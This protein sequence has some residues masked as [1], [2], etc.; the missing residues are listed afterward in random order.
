[1]RCLACAHRCDLGE[2]ETGICGVRFVREGQL[3]APSG[4]ISAAV[5]EPIEKKPFFHALPGARAFS[6]G[7]L[8]C[9]FHCDYCWNW[10]V[11]QALKD[12]EAGSP[13]KPAT[14]DSI[15]ARATAAGCAAVVATYSEPLVALEWCVDVLRAAR[16]AGLATAL[17]TNGAATPEAV[18]HLAP[19]TDLCKVDLKCFTERGYR[20]LGGH[21]DPVCE[22]IGRLVGAGIWVEVVTPVMAGFNDTED[23]LVAA[24]RFL[25]GVSPDL[26]WHLTSVFATVRART[27]AVPSPELLAGVA[28][29]ARAAGLRYVYPRGGRSGTEDTH[30]ASCGAAIVRREGYKMVECTI[31]DGTCPA[32]RTLVPGRWQN[33]AARNS[34]S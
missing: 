12:P 29:Q 9:S 7:M 1:V 31:E 32:C 13:P 3:R 25:A 5:A 23:E 20:T 30:C 24:A 2:G 4:Y 6:F 16:A 21:L 28:R 26:P 34:T 17:V 19:W 10:P 22:T 15:A 33:P 8:G 18:R 11:S 27:T 14:P